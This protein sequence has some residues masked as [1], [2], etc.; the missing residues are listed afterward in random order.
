M[1]NWE[2]IDSFHSPM[3]FNRFNRWIEQQI[4]KKLF[5]EIFDYKGRKDLKSSRYFKCCSSGEIWK[6]AEPDPGYFS[7]AWV[8]VEHSENKT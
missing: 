3:E 1:S 5:I 7:W 4:K 6:L 8:L 2:E